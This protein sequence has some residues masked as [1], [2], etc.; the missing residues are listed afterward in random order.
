[1]WQGIH[2]NLHNWINSYLTNRTYA[3]RYNNQISHRFTSTSGVPQGSHLGPILF[4]IFINDIVS[5]IEHANILIYADD[6][7]VYVKIFSPLDVSAL[8]R[9][10]SN[11][12]DWSP[13]N[14]LHLNINKCCVTS[15]NKNKDIFKFSYAI[16]SIPLSRVSEVKDLGIIFD[17]GLN[18]STT[19]IILYARR[20][21][22]LA[23]SEDP[24][25]TS[26]IP[27]L[28]SCYTGPW[29]YLPYS[30]DVKY[31]LHS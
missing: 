12:S 18:S 17:S 15:F 13:L 3:V 29:S 5:V 27:T 2:G 19:S 14:G 7:K 10:L 22:N 1:M 28:L 25:P 23:F 24:L 20:L 31:G 11:L 6:V 26:L 4:C 16:N 8:Q 21:G 30:M 9:D